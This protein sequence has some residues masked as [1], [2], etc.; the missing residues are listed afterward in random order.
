MLNFLLK[1]FFNISIQEKYKQSWKEEVTDLLLGES[2]NIFKHLV[3]LQLAILTF[4]LS[5]YQTIE[6][7]AVSLQ[8]GNVYYYVP[9]INASILMLVSWWLYRT[10]MKYVNTL[11][12][13]VDGVTDSF[14]M[15]NIFSPL[16]Q[17]LKVER[18][19][20]T[21]SIDHRH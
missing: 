14:T 7:A 5:V 11:K 18:E 13:M 21:M 9:L 1:Y 16:F 10:F 4:A 2:V 20:F 17:Q 12:L 19:R 3:L 15:S 6:Y 8:N